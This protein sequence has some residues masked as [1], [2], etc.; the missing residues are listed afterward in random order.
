MGVG[1]GWV[2]RAA[3]Q[4]VF[5]ITIVKKNNFESFHQY[6]Y[7]KKLLIWSWLLQNIVFCQL[8]LTD[9]LFALAFQL[10]KI[11]VLLPIHISPYF[12]QPCPTVV[13]LTI[14]LI[15]NSISNCIQA[16]LC[17][18]EWMLCNLYSTTCYKNTKSFDDTLMMIS[19]VNRFQAKIFWIFLLGKIST[20]FDKA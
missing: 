3:S 8:C 17:A 6:M 10:L 5:F 19:K 15:S 16:Q 2:W 20:R 18:L 14:S 1:V 11:I 7:D 12:A 13:L 4:A 9:Q